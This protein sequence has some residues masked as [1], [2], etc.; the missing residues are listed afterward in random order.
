MLI[1]EE[2][3]VLEARV[4]MWLKAQLDYDGIVVA[5]DM[6]VDSVEALEDLADK[7]GEG[8]WEWVACAFGD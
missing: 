1:D 5:I 2:D 3:I 8:L 4:E 6:R 7:G